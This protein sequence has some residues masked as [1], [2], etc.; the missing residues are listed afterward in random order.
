MPLYNDNAEGISYDNTTSGLTGTNVQ[1]AIDELASENTVPRVNTI[2]RKITILASA[3]LTI[4]DDFGHMRIVAPE[5]SSAVQG[6]LI[7]KSVLINSD[8]SMSI[9]STATVQI[10][11]V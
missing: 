6:M 8:A 10:L 11:G 9:T 4:F 5:S 7:N 3:A 2:V 1:T